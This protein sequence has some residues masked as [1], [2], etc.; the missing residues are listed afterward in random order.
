MSDQKE[1]ISNKEDNEAIK[2][3]V[4]KRPWV[5]PRL[6]ELSSEYAE[7]GTKT[8]SVEATTTTDTTYAPNS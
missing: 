1:I 6:Y 2:A 4:T 8:T 3:T 7:T 5:T